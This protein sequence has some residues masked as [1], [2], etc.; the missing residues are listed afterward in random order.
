MPSRIFGTIG[1]REWARTEFYLSGKPPMVESVRGVFLFAGIWMEK[2]HRL[3]LKAPHD[4]P[5]PILIPS[6]PVPPMDG[7]LFWGYR[8]F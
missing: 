3:F 1:N 4:S 5:V 8:E 2:N 6:S 7:S